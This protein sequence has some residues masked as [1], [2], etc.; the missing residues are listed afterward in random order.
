M[1]RDLPLLLFMRPPCWTT[2]LPTNIHI[3]LFFCALPDTS[4]LQELASP[5]LNTRYHPDW[6]VSSTMSPTGRRF[7]WTQRINF[8]K[9]NLHTLS[10]TNDISFFTAIQERIFREGAHPLYA[11]E[12]TVGNSEAKKIFAAVESILQRMA[13]AHEGAVR[14][15][16]ER[17]HALVSLTASTNEGALRAHLH[18]DISFFRETADSAVDEAMADAV[19][20]INR[21]PSWG[22]DHAF[23]L[24]VLG[25]TFVAPAIK[26][27]LLRL[28]V[29]E[30]CKSYDDIA[31]SDVA[32]EEAKMAVATMTKGLHGV[33][34]NQMS[35]ADLMSPT[36]SD[37]DEHQRRSKVSKAEKGE[38]SSADTAT[39]MWPALSDTELDE[40]THQDLVEQHRRRRRR[41]S[42]VTGEPP[43]LAELKE[44]KH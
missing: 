3:S 44:G 2:F 26:A 23:D 41:T 11:L 24:V 22:M 37:V 10:L 4:N 25:T 42:E 33:V 9:H 30:S 31:K 32:V 36:G 19:A 13:K 6:Q 29:L 35:A 39:E 15:V 17:F 43:T 7:H 20:L 12:Q 40:A 21:Q 1:S 34:F 14:S 5:L 27:C 18:A 28:A 38:S 8:I 16:R